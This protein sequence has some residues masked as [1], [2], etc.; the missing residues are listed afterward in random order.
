MGSYNNFIKACCL[1][2][3]VYLPASHTHT[4]IQT[5][6]SSGSSR[7]RLQFKG[8]DVL[9]NIVT[10]KRTTSS[11]SNDGSEKSPS[12]PSSRT[13]PF[14]NKVFHIPKLTKQSKESTG[15]D[16]R[17]KTASGQYSVA[18]RDVSV[19]ERISHKA[20]NRAQ[21]VRKPHEV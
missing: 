20:Q 16:S 6:K 5:T 19:L 10:R 11:S 7:R 1:R 2:V 9:T 14:L 15:V 4:H 3:V 12:R 18:P 8:K 17:V 13:S 21:R